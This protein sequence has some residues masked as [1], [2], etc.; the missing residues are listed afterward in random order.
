MG[1]YISG[2]GDHCRHFRFRG[3]RGGVG[4]NSADH[5]FRFHR[6]IGHFSDNEL[7]SIND[8]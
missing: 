2:R 8:E 6:F 3:N 7:R 5:F 1:A 4:W